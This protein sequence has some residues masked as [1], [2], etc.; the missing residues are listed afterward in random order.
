MQEVLKDKYLK[1]GII[2]DRTDIVILSMNL[3]CTSVEREPK[4]IKKI[5]SR[6]GRQTEC[7]LLENRKLLRAGDLHRKPGN[8]K[9]KLKGIL[10]VNPVPQ[11]TTGQGHHK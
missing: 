1:E 2:H 4:E 3:N 10:C 7:T 11:S 6:G 5:K 9:W 8:R